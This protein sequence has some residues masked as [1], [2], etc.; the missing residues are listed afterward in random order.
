[1]FYYGARTPCLMYT[2]DIMYELLSGISSLNPLRALKLME[3]SLA[4]VTS[5]AKM[6][7]MII[8]HVDFVASPPSSGFPLSAWKLILA[9]RLFTGA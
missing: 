6:I 8:T 9:H 2:R 1:M 4:A 5:P 7:K 3:D